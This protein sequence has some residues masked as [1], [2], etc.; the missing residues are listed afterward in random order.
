[1]DN[2]PEVQFKF[3]SLQN[4]A[5]LRDT[6]TQRIV[7]SHAARTIK[8]TTKL[9]EK[10]MLQNFRVLTVDDMQQR[11]SQDRLPASLDLKVQPANHLIDPFTTLPRSSR[12]LQELINSRK[13]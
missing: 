6:S 4:P 3:I 9:R 11:S 8:R 1:M 12:R 10:R 5:A 13:C 7:R 2:L